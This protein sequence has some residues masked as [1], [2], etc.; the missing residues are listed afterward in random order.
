MCGQPKLYDTSNGMWPNT[1]HWKALAI[2]TKKEYLGITEYETLAII[3][4][5]NRVRQ[6]WLGSVCR[7]QLWQ[8]APLMSTR[9]P[10]HT[11]IIP[12]PHISLRP[13]KWTLIKGLAS[14]TIR[15]TLWSYLYASKHETLEASLVCV[16]GKGVET[17]LNINGAASVTRRGVWR[18]G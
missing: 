18:C 5:A 4:A 14:P 6:I 3:P 1:K 7:A 11:S 12:R 13:C 16:S 8:N 15:Q 10:V 2:T 17:A 9:I